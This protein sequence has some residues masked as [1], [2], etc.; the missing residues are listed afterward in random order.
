MKI[1]VI[2]HLHEV[3]KEKNLS[4]EVLAQISGVEEKII[5]DI[6][7]DRYDPTIPMVCMLAEALETSTENLYSYMI[8]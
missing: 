2:Y 7:C 5:H 6:E 1:E 3:R 4:R 8:R